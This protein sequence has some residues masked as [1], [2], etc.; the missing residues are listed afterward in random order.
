MR[1]FDPMRNFPELDGLTAAEAKAL[2]IKTQRHVTRQPL[3]LIGLLAT[4]AIVG[5]L[6]FYFLPISGLLGGA[7]IGV[8]IGFAAV[9]Y[10]V[11]VIKPQMRA[12]FH[13]QGFPHL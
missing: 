6:I 1:S 11:A 2:V 3:T 9:L 7:I 12:E 8:L 13:R 10:M 5:V 4:L